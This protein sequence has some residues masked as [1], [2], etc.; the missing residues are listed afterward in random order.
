MSFKNYYDILGVQK[1]A[2]QTEIKKAY[3]KLSIKFHPDKNNGDEF[4]GEMFKNINEA[5]EIL[6]DPTKRKKYDETLK[7]ISPSFVKS[8]QANN[9][10]YK[11]NKSLRDDF[12]RMNELLKLYFDK[13]LVAKKKH[14]EYKQAKRIPKPKYLTLSKLLWT[15]LIMLGIYWFFKPSSYYWKTKQQQQIGLNY[16]TWI[17]KEN[18]N[19]FS[20]PDISSLKIDKVSVGTRF[21][22]PPETKYFIEIKI[23]DENGIERK[24]YVRKRKLKKR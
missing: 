21:I 12:K 24:G 18:A 10:T 14:I 17:V 7:N 15:I 6:S 23:T 9:Q 1:N 5:Y 20:E 16:N 2:S 11:Q 8:N 22:N 19:V 13:E 3:R 4:L